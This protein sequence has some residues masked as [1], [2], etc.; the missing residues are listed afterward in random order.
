MNTLNQNEPKKKKLKPATIILIIVASVVFITGIIVLSI[1][2]FNADMSKATEYINMGEYDK[3]KEILDKQLSTNP[4]QNKVYLV[5][6]DYYLAQNEYLNAVEILEQGIPRCSNE[7]DLQRKLED[8]KS[9]Y[10]SEIKLEQEQR[11]QEEEKK[12]QEEEQ[13]QWEQYVLECNEIDY[14]DLARNPNKFKGQ[15]F[16]FTGKIIQVIEPTWGNTV[17]LRI[18]VTKS[19]LG[20]YSDTIYATVELAKDADRILEN[21]IVTIYGDCDGL[22]TYTSLLG[23][24]VSVPKID[25]KYF[26]INN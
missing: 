15:S 25:I 14:S 24:S 5:F 21:D 17:S 6:A 26:T 16:K 13:K 9:A 12:K 10:A 18:N 2:L 20:L 3:A 19:E 1:T 7:G 11:K 22:Y 8:I 23:A 4:S